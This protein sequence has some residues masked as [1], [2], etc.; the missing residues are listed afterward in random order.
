MNA[1]KETP[2]PLQEAI[3]G[4]TKIDN[5]EID[6]DDAP[7]KSHKSLATITDADGNGSTSCAITCRSAGPAGANSA[8]TSSAIP[9]ISG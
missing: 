4:R 9:G 5:I 3:I 2:T 7:R 6:D 8:P 1:W